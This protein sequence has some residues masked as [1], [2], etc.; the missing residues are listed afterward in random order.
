MERE[1]QAMSIAGWPQTVE[2][3]ANRLHVNNS[4]SPDGRA[5]AR[6]HWQHG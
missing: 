2:Q 5:V 4:R 1:D 3:V 6:T